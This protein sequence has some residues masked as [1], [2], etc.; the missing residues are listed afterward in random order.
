MLDAHFIAER[1][2]SMEERARR[3]DA[4]VIKKA[5]KT[6]I[7][8]KTSSPVLSAIGSRATDDAVEL[9]DGN[10]DRIRSR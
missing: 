5:M 6:T 4:F 10:T 3:S 8:T 9:T 7:I 1:K 2:G